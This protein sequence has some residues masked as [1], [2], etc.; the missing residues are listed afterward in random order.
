M[1]DLAINSPMLYRAL[2]WG[3]CKHF[4]LG[5]CY[6]VGHLVKVCVCGIFL[7][8]QLIWYVHT[9]MKTTV[10]CDIVVNIII[11]MHRI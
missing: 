6:G 8:L 2:G 10:V 9:V 3:A 7:A 4:R 11:N 5:N 1:Y